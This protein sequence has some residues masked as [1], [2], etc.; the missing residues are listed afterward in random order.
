MIIGVT[1]GIGSGKTTFSKALEEKGAYLIDADQ[2]VSTLYKYDKDLKKQVSELFGETIMMDDQLD[3]RKIVNIVTADKNK[4]NELNKIVHKRVE[5]EIKKDIEANSKKGI[6]VLDVPI[7]TKTGFMDVC[8]VIIVVNSFIRNRIDR[9]MSRNGIPGYEAKKR[10]KMQISQKEY[11]KIADHIIT[12]NGSIEDL[13]EK[14][15]KLLKEV[16]R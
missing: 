14:A 5:E 13:K 8:D 1:G 15:T 3:R 12:N 10:M 11:V 2:I 6:I 4:L 9:I 16:T 7:P